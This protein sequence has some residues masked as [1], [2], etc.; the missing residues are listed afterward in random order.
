MKRSFYHIVNDSDVNVFEPPSKRSNTNKNF[1]KISFFDNS[2]DN[3]DCWG[4]YQTLVWFPWMTIYPFDIPKDI[5][6]IIAIYATGNIFFCQDVKCNKETSETLIM[7]S[8]YLN[9]NWS[10]KFQICCNTQCNEYLTCCKLETNCLGCTN[11]FDCGNC[12][13]VKCLKYQKCPACSVKGWCG[14][15]N[16]CDKCKLVMCHDCIHSDGRKDNRGK[17]F[18]AH[19]YYNPWS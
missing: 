19:C 1:N 10:S 2:I 16:Q 13:C 5:S 12:F 17:Y 8:F 6:R 18:C 7:N 4:I 3:A 14:R 15:W 11:G 9:E